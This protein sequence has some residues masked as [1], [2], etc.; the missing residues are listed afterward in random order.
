MGVKQAALHRDMQAL[1]DRERD[2]FASIPR[3]FGKTVQGVAS[4]AYDIGRNPDIRVKYVQQNDNEASK[5][6]G[7]IQRTLESEAYQRVFPH[8]KPDRRSWG[9]LAFMVQRNKAMRD[10]TVEASGIFGRAGGRYDLLVGDDI[11]DLQNSIQ[12]PAQRERVKEAWSNTW[13]P[14]ADMSAPEPPRVRACGTPWH[15]DDI[16]AV[17]KKYYTGSSILWAPCIGFE[18][19]WPE[20]F[21][22]A[23]LEAKKAKGG[24]IAY[25][26]AYL[27]QPLSDDD[28]PIKAQWIRFARPGSVASMTRYCGFDLAYTDKTSSD[29]SVFA[30][31]GLDVD[32]SIYLLR[33]LRMKAAYPEVKRAAMAF[34]Q[35]VQWAEMRGLAGGAEIGIM[36][37]LTRGLGFPVSTSEKG[38]KYERAS[39]AAVLFE[40]GRVN[41]PGADG[42][43]DPEWKIAFDELT[44]FPV[45]AHD[46][47]LDAIC[48]GLEL[49]GTAGTNQVSFGW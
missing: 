24:S 14:M 35:G 42:L 36:D 12:Q 25:A 11:C 34:L 31:V 40:A 45:A 4:I 18:S 3:G 17:W 23:A 46:D 26:R 30:D 6:V 1:W 21:T 5:T 13:L 41:M 33:L 49:A 10:P 32:G 28:T 7:L 29:F 43:P 2:S 44:Q 22:P 37:D 27:L 9:K 16:M 39:R 15:V 47:C 8:I 20:V 38:S 48:N 19:P